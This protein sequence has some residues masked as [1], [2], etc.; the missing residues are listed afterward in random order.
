MNKTTIMSEKDY[1]RMATKREERRLLRCS[2]KKVKLDHVTQ[3]ILCGASIKHWY[4]A[5]ELAAMKLPGLPT[6]G[7]GMRERAKNE[8][9]DARQVPGKGGK[10]GIKT[11]YFIPISYRTALATQPQIIKEVAVPVESANEPAVPAPGTVILTLTLSLDEA[12]YIT[13]W[14]AQQAQK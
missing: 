14:L 6:S 5:D 10:N 3:Q 1:S 9:W 11:E 7:R 4:G 8:K 2:R 12:A 13:G